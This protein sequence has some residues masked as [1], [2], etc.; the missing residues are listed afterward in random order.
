MKTTT[1]RYNAEDL[2][3]VEVIKQ[4]YGLLTDIDVLRFALRIVAQSDMQLTTHKKSKEKQDGT[5]SLD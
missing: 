5:R 2:R 4:R 1:V 3:A